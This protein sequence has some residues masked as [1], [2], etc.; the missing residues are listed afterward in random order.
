MREQEAIWYIRNFGCGQKYS[1]LKALNVHDKYLF[2]KD[3]VVQDLGENVNVPSGF[4]PREAIE[5]IHMIVLFSAWQA[6]HAPPPPRRSDSIDC[7]NVGK[8]ASLA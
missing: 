8:R 3:F 7:R 4:R 6:A 5:R 1:G 2:V